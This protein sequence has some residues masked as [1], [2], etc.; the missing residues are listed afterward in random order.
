MTCVKRIW[1]K[2]TMVNEIIT[3]AENAYRELSVLLL[4][5]VNKRQVKLYNTINVR[6]LHEIEGTQKIDADYIY[7]YKF[8]GDDVERLPIICN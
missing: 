6:G 5:K 7:Q 1:H 3:S 2:G 4:N 8:T